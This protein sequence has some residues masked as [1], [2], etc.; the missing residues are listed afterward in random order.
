MRRAIVTLLISVFAVA[1]W[2]SAQT[3]GPTVT[4]VPAK[5]GAGSPSAVK[6]SHAA[7]KPTVRRVGR[8]KP[9]AAKKKAATQRPAAKKPAATVKPLV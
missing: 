6:A 2:A 5:A 9:A 4:P 7:K 1:P 8:K 3:P